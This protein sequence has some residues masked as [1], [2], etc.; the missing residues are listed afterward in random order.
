MTGN[1]IRQEVRHLINDPKYARFVE[2]DRAYRRLCRATKFNWL[3]ASSEDLLKIKGDDTGPYVISM[4][5]IRVLQRI[6]VKEPDDH[7][8]WRMM[9]EVPV[10]LFESKV[11]DNRNNDAT[12]QTARPKF[13]KLEGG[14]DLSVTVTPSPDSDYTTRVDYIRF[15]QGVDGATKIA[16]PPAYHDTLAR[17]AAGYI[18]E[19][20][21][22]S[23]EDFGKGKAWQAEAMGDVEDMVEDSHPNRTED[24]DRV[25]LV[26]L[27]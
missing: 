5:G 16:M 21:A 7:E 18:M 11:S 26:W 22:I 14:P 9:E 25:P 8:R 6:W 17:L 10:Q 13:Y 24:I 12:D 3:R 15:I 2:I 20:R 1:E 4:D 23:P 19:H 27:R